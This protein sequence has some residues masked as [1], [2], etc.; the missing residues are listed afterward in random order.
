MRGRN[1]LKQGCTLNLHL[2]DN[3]NYSPLYGIKNAPG[4]L[5]AVGSVGHYLSYS[6]D[7][8][9]VFISEDG[10]LNWRHVADGEHIYEI[11]D[12]GGLIVMTEY[13]KTTDLVK[14]TY[15]L[16]R[17]W[18]FI[19]FLDPSMAKSGASK[20]IYKA[21]EVANIVIEPS[22]NNHQFLVV[23]TGKKTKKGYS[24]HLDFSEYH[25]RMCIGYD[26]PDGYSSDYTKFIPHTLE[27][28][29]C[30]FSV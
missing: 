4:V 16:G 22:N 7:E 27:D 11:G 9:G 29:K 14:F 24:A 8:L 2:S 28:E 15:D 17:T 6:P 18:F 23:G 19:R 20:S 1:L 26:D 13:R 5:V 12:Q 3:P 25:S 30:S 10:G 21:I